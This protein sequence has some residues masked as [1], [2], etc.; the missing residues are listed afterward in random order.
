[1]AIRKPGQFGCSEA[2]HRLIPAGAGPEA[3]GD[4]GFVVERAGERFLVAARRPLWKARG[5]IAD[6]ERQ[7]RLGPPLSLKS[8]VLAVRNQQLVHTPSKADM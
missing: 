7:I 3:L 8:P 2:V 1:M 4:R 5:G 6:E